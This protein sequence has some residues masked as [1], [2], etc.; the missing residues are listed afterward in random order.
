MLDMDT[1]SSNINGTK[2]VRID[3]PQAHQYELIKVKNLYNI[4]KW[5]YAKN[6][7]DRFSMVRNATSMF[8]CEDCKCSSYSLILDKA[9]E[10][11]ETIV[12][13][14]DI[15]LKGNIKEYFQERHKVREMINN[16]SKDIL[17][18]VESIMELIN[19]NI[20]LSIGLAISAILS[21]IAKVNTNILRIF[22]AIYIVY[23][24]VI[25]LYYFIYSLVKFKTIKNDYNEHIEAFK[26]I[27]MP[28]DMPE[29]K[30]S[31]IRRS[32]ITFR[33]FWVLSLVITLSLI[34]IS[35]FGYNNVNTFAEWLNTISEIKK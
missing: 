3:F 13:N 14:F 29:Y 5:I 2:K 27:L 35:M 23:L 9:N 28:S 8:L 26:K 34:G 15:Y 20:L 7:S 11:Y 6:Y 33:V 22:I 1:G 18:E 19:K 10:I 30:K 12:N 32:F 17:K 16:K 25:G 24:T 4:Y 21:Y 31:S